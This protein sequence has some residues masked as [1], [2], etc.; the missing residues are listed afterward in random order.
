MRQTLWT[1][2]ILTLLII[3]C[4]GDGQPD[5]AGE[6]AGEP[7]GVMAG[8]PAG[9]MA[10]SAPEDVEPLPGHEPIDMGLEY[11]GSVPEG[12]RTE[13]PF[14]VSSE[15]N[16]LIFTSDGMG[17]CPSGEDTMLALYALSPS[18]QRTQ[19]DDDDDGGEGLCSRIEMVLPAGNY[20]AEV[21]GF[22]DRAVTSYVVNIMILTRLAEG[23]ACDLES[24][25]SGICEDG[26]ACVEN[27]C[28]SA[29][30]VI[31]SGTA[32]AYQDRLVVSVEGAD[33][34]QNARYLDVILYDD[35]L[36]EVDYIFANLTQGEGTD[37]TGFYSGAGFD[38]TLVT[39]VG[40]VPLDAD[41]NEGEE[42]LVPLSELPILSAGDACEVNFSTGRCEDGFICASD[43]DPSVTE[44]VQ[45]VA[46]S[47]N[48]P[49]AYS[50]AGR[51]IL[52]MNGADPNEDI[53][54]M[55]LTLYD[56]LG[57]V[58]SVEG[59]PSARLP[60]YDIRDG[61]SPGELR[62]LSLFE[63]FDAYPLAVAV[64]LTLIDA[65]GLTSAPLIAVI[66]PLPVS[67]IGASCDLERLESSCGPYFCV[68]DVANGG[69]VCIESL[70][71]FGEDCVQEIGCEPGLVCYGPDQGVGLEA[72][73]GTCFRACDEN[74]VEL[75][76]V[77]GCEANEACVPDFPWREFG[78]TEFE[79]PGFC[80]PNQGCDPLNTTDACGEGDFYCHRYTDTTQCL[81][82]SG[83][84]PEVVMAEGEECNGADIICQAGLVCEFNQCRAGCVDDSSCATGESCILADGGVYSFCMELCDLYAQDCPNEEVCQVLT[85][86]NGTVITQCAEGSTQGTVEPGG[87][88]DPLAGDVSGYWGDCAGP[89]LCDN[90]G[91][92]ETTC[93]ELC[94]QEDSP[95]VGETTC[96]ER[97]LNIDGVGLCFGDCDPFSGVGCGQ[98]E[99][100][101]LVGQGKNQAG[102]DK[103]VGLC[104][105]NL[106]Q[107][108]VPTGGSCVYE[109]DS[110]TSDCAPGHLCA[111]IYNT[112][113]ECV[114][115]CSVDDQG[116]P[117]IECM[118]AQTCLYEQLGEPVFENIPNLGVCIN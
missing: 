111:D 53:I 82:L 69:G 12:E 52:A 39:Q 81:E 66:A 11:T 118:G 36:F 44:C 103:I 93:Y 97:L 80:L 75:G 63:T 35:M 14:F 98:D 79:S 46:P 99:S 62:Y 90:I 31:N 26:L 55:E 29:L 68:T 16:V 102:E 3:G 23:E 2:L 13:H 57:E 101:V 25:E 70:P 43:L 60:F 18:G 45:G 54:E 110:G 89:A 100:C 4:D 28:G 115:L 78:F 20:I 42:L 15:S 92:D 65:S 19:L 73:F 6:M 112:G 58:I 105:G 30:P 5:P 48:T 49:S 50:D 83:F 88:C 24:P 34:D 107:G 95:C 114:Q 87:V 37:F 9:V 109:P 64:E 104:V 8:E 116:Q 40:L 59:Q 17:G 84:D 96:V 108:A 22:A 76:G 10:G 32:Y 47:A 41:F 67:A 91:A 85:A 51:L 74:G 38:F 72:L 7:A 94:S 113:D 86:Q 71:A 21:R 27:V 61:A 117:V 77:V 1:P 56:E 106:N 33:P